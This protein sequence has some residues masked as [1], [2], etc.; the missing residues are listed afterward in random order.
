MLRV[1]GVALHDREQRREL[2]TI[3][4]TKPRECLLLGR[5]YRGRR[6]GEQFKS[7]LRDGGVH[8][9]SVIVIAFSR[10]QAAIFKPV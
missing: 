9:A 7:F 4:R 6:N 10:H 2:L 1:W 3:G 5:P 8:H